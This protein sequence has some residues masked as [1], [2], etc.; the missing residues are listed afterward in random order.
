MAKESLTFD[1]IREMAL[2]LADV[3]EASSYGSPALRITK[4]GQGRR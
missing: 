4:A 3:N 1:A 2:T